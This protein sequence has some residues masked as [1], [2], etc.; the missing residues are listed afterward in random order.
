MALLRVGLTAR[1]VNLEHL[2]VSNGQKLHQWIPHRGCGHNDYLRDPLRQDMSSLKSVD[3]SIIDLRVFLAWRTPCESA[4]R[5][6][7]RYR[8]TLLSLRAAPRG[9]HESVLRKRVGNAH[10]SAKSGVQAG[11]QSVATI[12][13]SLCDTNRQFGKSGTG[14]SLSSL[15]ATDQAVTSS[16][17]GRLKADVRGYA[18]RPY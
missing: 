15:S 17:I 9:G 8:R 16:Q 2:V 12:D 5:G 4:E 11:V 10:G 6:H 3:D 7:V 14:R 18:P 13:G 1:D